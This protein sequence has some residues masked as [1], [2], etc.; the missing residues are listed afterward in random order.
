[1]WWY[2]GR[3]EVGKSPY[4]RTVCSEIESAYFTET[5]LHVRLDHKT[6]SR[7]A[8]GGKPKSQSNAEKGWLLQSEADIIIN[9]A[10][11]TA[12]RGFPLSHRRLREHVNSILRGRL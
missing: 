9:F 10:I 7:L 2:K 6:L 3:R 4:M 8:G 1:M 12:A 5:G 11:E